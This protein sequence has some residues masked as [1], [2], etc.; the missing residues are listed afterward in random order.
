MGQ[1]AASTWI[2]L[3]DEAQEGVWRWEADNSIMN[4]PF[5]APNQ[6]D[7]ARN[8]QCVVMDPASGWRDVPCTSRRATTCQLNCPQQSGI[9]GLPPAGQQGIV[10]L[11]PGGQQGIV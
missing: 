4:V 3:T 10:G 1:P 11:P 2:G 6:P 9:V 5:W 7:G 8:E